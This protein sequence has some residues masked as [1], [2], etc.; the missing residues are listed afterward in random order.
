MSLAGGYGA[1]APPEL[2]VVVPT[3][4]RADLL[5]GCLQTLDDQF[6]GSDRY[7]IVVVDDHSEDRTADVVKQMIT[8]CPLQYVKN[9]RHGLLAA[10]NYGIEVAVGDYI[11]FLADTILAPPTLLEAH[12]RAH[13]EYHHRVIRGPVIPV[14]DYRLPRRDAT[15]R[16]LRGSFTALNASISKLAL[17]RVGGFR[18]DDSLLHQERDIGWRLR[19]EKWPERF[20]REAY[21]YRYAGCEDEEAAG[22]VE[23][24]RMDAESAVAHYREYPDIGVA[25]RTG[26]HPLV[27]IPGRLTRG[28]AARTL[29]EMLASSGLGRIPWMQEL[30]ERR[31][32]LC[33]YQQ[34][35]EEELERA[36]L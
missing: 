33:H 9:P 18:E 36:E 31:I 27:R 16:A 35:L 6:L 15:P 7:E 10:R 30:L 3:R 26:I 17:T 8:H 20:L 28:R 21:C 25:L 22:L 11:L 23:Q 13:K 12:Y 19:K 29:W 32:Y 34:T 14:Q 5:A 4:N 24:A 2:S 1:K